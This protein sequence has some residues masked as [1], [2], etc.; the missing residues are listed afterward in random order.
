MVTKPNRAPAKAERLKIKPQRGRMPV[1]QILPPDELEIDETYQR[2]IEAADSQGLIKRIAQ[3]WNWDLCQPLVVS[4]RRGDAGERE[5]FFVIDGQHRLAAA[6]L[7]GDIWQLPCVVLEFTSAADE[8][9]SF[10]HLNQ[11]RRPLSKLQL[12]KAA[13]A[14][15]DKR[16]CA[17]V[18][19]LRDVGLQVATQTNTHYWRAGMVSNVAGIEKA[20]DKYGEIVTRCALRAL[21]DAFRGQILQYAGTIFPGIVA[22]CADE[23]DR[24]SR[25]EE[26]R[27]EKFLTMLG[28]RTQ[29]QWRG[30]ISLVKGEQPDMGFGA[31]AAFALRKRWSM[32]APVLIEPAPVPRAIAK[33]AGTKACANAE[34]L[35]PYSGTR[36]CEQCDMKISFAELS[37]CKSRW[38]SLRKMG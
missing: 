38:C 5:R 31:A 7:R 25:F 29:V 27:F 3:Q 17:I 14:S 21:S 20:W 6:R 34:G 24:A 16:A 1:L 22:I 10:V 4:R 8:A 2:S 26:G 32:A 23:F 37:S 9:A 28:K 11:L 33:S 18:E 35:E 19:A 13:V 36:W 12:F 15:G 30:E